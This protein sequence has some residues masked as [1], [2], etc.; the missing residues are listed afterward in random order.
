VKLNVN[1]QDYTVPDGPDRELL[2]V[3]H[4]EL[5]LPGLRFGCT[6]GM[7]GT[8]LVLVDGKA[9]RACCFPVSAVGNRPVWTRAGLLAAKAR[10]EGPAAEQTRQEQSDEAIN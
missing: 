4:D 7:C 6:V 9:T 8:C 1:G 5:G 2:W 3:L 10:G